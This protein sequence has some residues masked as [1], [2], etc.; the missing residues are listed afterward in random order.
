MRKIIA[1]F[2]AVLLIVSLTGCQQAPQTEQEDPVVTAYLDAVQTYIADGDLDTAIT[3]LEEG[4]KETGNNEKLAKL[5]ED[6]KNQKAQQETEPSTDT[7]TPETPAQAPVVSN[8]PIQIDMDDLLS[9]NLLGETFYSAYESGTL[10]HWMFLY[11]HGTSDP[12]TVYDAQWFDAN[13]GQMTY[14]GILQQQAADAG[15]GDIWVELVNGTASGTQST[16]TQA[17]IPEAFIGTWREPGKDYGLSLT[18]TQN[19][20][21]SLLIQVS[22][23][24]NPSATRLVNFDCIVPYDAFFDGLVKFTYDNDGWGNTGTIYLERN[25]NSVTCT[26]QGVTYIGTAGFAMWGLYEGEYLLT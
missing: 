3:V 23:V 1:G 18:I 6:V 21:S 14:Y 9:A 17:N 19:D 10:A 22:H 24:N 15:W 25:D 8:Y 20:S 7:T 4:C 11:V 26:V 12:E 2:L 5:L 13:I 16:S